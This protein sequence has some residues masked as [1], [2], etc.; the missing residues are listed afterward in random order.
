MELSPRI[1]SDLFHVGPLNLQNPNNFLLEDYVTACVNL[2][3]S[4]N[5]Q[6]LEV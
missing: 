5:G 6:K 3:W 1:G 2:K 4:Y